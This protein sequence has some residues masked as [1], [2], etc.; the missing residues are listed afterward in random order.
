MKKWKQ[1]VVLNDE[2]I[3]PLGSVRKIDVGNKQVYKCLFS[4]L[5]F[6]KSEIVDVFENDTDEC[7][8]VKINDMFID[9]EKVYE[10]L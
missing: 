4:E 5:T 9:L 3:A 7:G 6:S 8:Y 1:M 2:F 10:E